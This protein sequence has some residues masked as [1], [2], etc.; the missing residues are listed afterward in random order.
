MR[1]V[2][3]TPSGEP[4]VEWIESALPGGRFGIRGVTVLNEVEG[5]S[6]LE[7]APELPQC[8]REIGDGAQGPRG[9]HDVDFFR[10]EVEPFAG[11]TGELDRSV[12]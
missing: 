2:E 3:M 4:L 8:R 1:R 12:R 11:Q 9:Q 7:D 5:A 6:R 10:R